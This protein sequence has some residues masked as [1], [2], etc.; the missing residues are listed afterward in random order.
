MTTEREMLRVWAWSS[1]ASAVVAPVVVLGIQIAADHVRV[2]EVLGGGV[3]AT[4][5]FGS[6][7]AVGLIAKDRPALKDALIITYVAKISLLMLVGL[8]LASISLDDVAFGLSI[9]VSA[10]VY[11]LV[12]TV[13]YLRSTH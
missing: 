10:V 12:Q 9:A 2:A 8:L 1:I 13:L 3:V 5:F 7:N 11:V 4:V 6:T